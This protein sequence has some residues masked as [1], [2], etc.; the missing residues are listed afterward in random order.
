MHLSPVQG[1]TADKDWRSQAE[2]NDPVM[3]LNNR[4][5]TRGTFSRPMGPRRLGVDSTH[6][7]KF[8]D[9]LVPSVEAWAVTVSPGTQETSVMLEAVLLAA[10]SKDRPMPNGRS[11][12]G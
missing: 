5:K 8:T 3:E 7:G 2:P 4:S 10:K 12:H 1:Q 11:E 6:E 9:A